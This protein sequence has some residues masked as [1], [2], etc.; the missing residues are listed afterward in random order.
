MFTPTYLAI[1]TSLTNPKMR[2]TKVKDENIE[3]DFIRLFIIP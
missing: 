2:E 3:A 1:N